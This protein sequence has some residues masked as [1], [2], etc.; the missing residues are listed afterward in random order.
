MGKVSQL[1]L[2]G[3]E[4][5]PAIRPQLG[6]DDRRLIAICE[7]LGARS[8]PG[9]S[10]EEEAL[11]RDLP[12]VSEKG[13]GELRNQIAAGRDPLGDLFCQLR[14]PEDRRSRGATYTP[15]L[16]ARTMVDWAES[17]AVPERVVDAGVGSG[18]FIVEAGRRFPRASLIGIEI[19]P[20]AAILARAHL[21]ASGLAA[22]STIIRAD[23]REASIPLI[24]GRTL[25]IGNPPYVRHHLIEADWKAW[26]I[27]EATKRGRSASQLAGLHVHFF[28]ATVMKARLGD[29]GAFI[30]AAEW[31]DVNYGSLVRE[32]FLADLGGQTITVIEPTALP[33]PDAA[34][35]AVITAFEIGS[36]PKSIFLTR[37]ATVEELRS[38]GAEHIVRRERLETEPR[39]S[40]LTRPA[41]KGPPGFIELGELCR[42]HRGQVTGANKVW[43][44]GEHSAGLPPSVFFPTVTKAKELFRAGRELADSS[45]LRRVIDLPVDLD[46][47]D[48]ADR[49][50]IDR[51]LT[52][53]RNQGVDKGYI[54]ST[55]KAWW[56][57]G[58]KRPA[59]ILA[60]YMARRPPAFVRNRADARHI[61]IAHGLYPREPLEDA[62]LRSLVE[63]LSTSTN[64]SEGRTYAGGLTKFEPREMER[65]LV[66]DLD[67]LR[68]GD[69]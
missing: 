65:L 19:D 23:Y 52:Q 5:Q 66:P 30:T 44:A 63:Y 54:A 26:L 1:T 39:W 12:R 7:R 8:V 36:Q 43:I 45:S 18:R 62:V 17:H 14:S 2:F 61:N 40:L 41:R 6:E 64:V 28:L 49:K 60:T 11:A 37:A 16:I 48:G 22:R 13:L 57:V 9:W 53:A 35:T 33:F 68:Q 46:V 55:R 25:F 27:R 51:F 38:P 34:T 21:A 42:V 59:P 3:Q 24:G 10:D 32:L 20:L 50:A 69:P 47:F 29:F 58:L 4:S 56:S 15:I 67:L 31:L